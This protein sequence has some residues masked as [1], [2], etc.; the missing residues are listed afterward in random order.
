MSQVDVVLTA[1]DYDATPRVDDAPA[2]ERWYLHQMHM[3]FNV[4]GHPA[5]VLPS[6]LSKKTGMP[7]SMQI[8]G[9]HFDESMVYRVAYTYEQL[10]GNSNLRPPLAVKH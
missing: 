8:V 1:S 9:H 4:S 10:S 3:P 6:G 7:L 2:I 5:L